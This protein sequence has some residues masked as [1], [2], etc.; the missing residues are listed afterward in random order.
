[1][2]QRACDTACSMST[3]KRWAV[4]MILLAWTT[5]AS[6]EE[7]PAFAKPFLTGDEEHVVVA[8]DAFGPATET[9]I[10]ITSSLMKTGSFAG[11]ALVPDAA[12]KDGY[13]KLPLPALPVGTNDGTM[14][15]ALAENLDKDPAKELVV[16]LH[17]SRA[18]ATNTYATY[19][20]VVLDWNGK[21]F[22]RVAA[23]EK[24]LAAAMKKGRPDPT[25]PFEKDELRAALGIK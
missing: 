13:R 5:V 3:I 20:Y 1:M 21:A 16:E 19:E 4:P 17:V 15:V 8:T 23:L 11:F 25:A 10:V 14:K 18:A 12:Q 22:V 2:E 9:S 6:A 7:T 24:K